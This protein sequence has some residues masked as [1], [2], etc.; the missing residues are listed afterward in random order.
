M[1]AADDE[2]VLAGLRCEDRSLPAD[3]EVVR[4]ELVGRFRPGDAE[5]ELDD[6]VDPVDDDLPGPHIPRLKVLGFQAALVSRST[7]GFVARFRPPPP[8]PIGNRVPI[9]L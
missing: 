6:R 7:T 2:V 1:L 4:L 5:I 9:L 3:R 8:D